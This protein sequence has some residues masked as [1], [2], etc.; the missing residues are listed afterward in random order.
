MSDFSSI[1]K[2]EEIIAGAKKNDSLA[3][4]SNGKD[5]AAV[6]GAVIA[7]VAVAG[8]LAVGAAQ[9]SLFSNG[10][11]AS[12]STQTAATE[13]IDTAASGVTSSTTSAQ[14]NATSAITQGP[15][16]G[17]NASL[18]AAQGDVNS[19][20]V[21]ATGLAG[22][23]KA[24]ADTQIAE[25][26]SRVSGAQ[27]YLA[28]QT[29]EATTYAQSGLGEGQSLMTSLTSA[30][31]A[32]TPPKVV[33]LVKPTAG[34]TPTPPL[35]VNVPPPAKVVEQEVPKPASSLAVQAPQNASTP[36]NTVKSAPA[37]REIVNIEQ[38]KQ[39]VLS[40]QELDRCR[41]LRDSIIQ[42]I[43]AMWGFWKIIYDRVPASGAVSPS[44]MQV[45]RIDG[46]QAIVALP[47]TFVRRYLASGIPSGD[48]GA[49]N[50]H[51]IQ[52][53]QAE[54][55]EEA[56]RLIGTGPLAG[57]RQWKSLYDK[58][59]TF[60]N[61]IGTCEELSIIKEATGQRLVFEGLMIEFNQLLFAGAKIQ[62]KDNDA[63]ILKVMEDIL[64]KWE[65]ITDFYFM[66][67]EE[68]RDKRLV[69]SK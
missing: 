29:S 39:V 32:K 58:L 5:A 37:T 57:S 22:E 14:A 3:C 53:I 10:V 12:G 9:S 41:E 46:R 63:A 68:F 6:A 45:V 61:Y 25:S 36:T 65:K 31:L 55:S 8:A 35:P 30:A 62:V 64:L 19:A 2:S 44:D 27:N 34:K 54:G 17:A 67:P 11:G 60:V 52:L 66:F 16:A 43:T 26:Q 33:G 48:L 42:D 51:S 59:T 50:A 49:K 20:Q 38:L 21:D 15:G 47:F 40:K 23:K 69:R 7:G 24:G 28:G 1:N 4:K 56:K 18:S 13:S